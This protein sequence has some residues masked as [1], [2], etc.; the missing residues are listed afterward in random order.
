MM[1]LHFWLVQTGEEMP[2]DGQQTRLLRTALLAK[3][4]V[5][6]GHRVTYWNSTFN[7]QKKIQRFES[8]TRATQADSYDCIFLY[9]R[10]YSRNVSVARLLSQR[11]NASAFRQRAPLE[12]K[13]D[14]I[15]CGFPT[16][17]LAEAVAEY[18]LARSIPYVVDCRDMWPEVIERHLGRSL[19]R[20]MSPVLAYW[21]SKRKFAFSQ[22]AAIIGVSNSFVEWGCKAAGRTP[23]SLDRA[24]FLAADTTCYDAETIKNAEAYWNNQIGAADPQCTTLMIAGNLSG[25]VDIMTAVR[26]VIA[27]KPSNGRYLKLV[28]CGKGDLEAEIKKISEQN[29]NIHFA[30]WRTGA[31][32]QQLAKRCA[33]G[34]LAYS[35]TDDLTASLPNKV[36]EYLSYGIPVITCLKGEIV[37]Q[38]GNRNVLI[39]YEEANIASATAVFESIC[40]VITEDMYQ[41]AKNCFHDFFDPV[42]IYSA[43]A[44]HLQGLKN[45]N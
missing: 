3:E 26:A 31:E 13:P 8:T 43:F 1:P 30:G 4:L 32:L 11:D 9:G 37:R 33:A 14:L 12:D 42:Q 29:A 39:P 35:N 6:R 5:S 2:I 28:V 24:F 38:L 44:D 23:Q 21:R 20:L 18:A 34:V 25:R 7:H 17:E 15:L 36:G 27:A 19:S 45:L 40:Q 41:S 16:I 10:E 22:A